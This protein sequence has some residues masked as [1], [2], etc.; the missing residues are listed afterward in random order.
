MKGHVTIPVMIPC[1]MLLSGMEMITIVQWI[2]ANLEGQVAV[3]TLNGFSMSLAISRGC[4]QAGVLRSPLLW[5]PVVDD[6]LARL[7]GNGVFIQGYTDDD[8][9]RW[10]NSQTFYQ[11]S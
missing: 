6:L 4:P 5:C 11:D 10:V 2:R 8:S 3:A 1:V 9:S 7:S